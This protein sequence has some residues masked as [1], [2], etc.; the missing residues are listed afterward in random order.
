MSIFITATVTPNLVGT[1]NETITIDI[2]PL[3]YYINY[4]Q[5]LVNTTSNVTFPTQKSVTFNI[6][7]NLANGSFS[8]NQY[9]GNYAM[10]NLTLNTQSNYIYDIMFSPTDVNK[11]YLI[12]ITTQPNSKLYDYFENINYG[13]CMN[14]SYN[15]LNVFNDCTVVNPSVY[16]TTTN[17]QSL[18]VV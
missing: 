9:I 3:Q 5:K 1:F 8:G 12:N 15:N 16:P 11:K 2:D 4:G 17:Y 14:P 18:S 7:M 13:V 10:S 6:S